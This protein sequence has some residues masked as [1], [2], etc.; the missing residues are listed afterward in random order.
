MIHATLLICGDQAR[1]NL[2]ARAEKSLS[3]G[4]VI[5]Q[6][7]DLVGR[8]RACRTTPT[9]S[10]AE[11]VATEPA[12]VL[13]GGLTVLMSYYRVPADELGAREEHY[14]SERLSHAYDVKLR[15]ACRGR[16]TPAAVPA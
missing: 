5:V 13:R 7:K 1:A 4:E 8:R 16:A 3:A 2:L 11:L 9:S 10:K 14:E 15:I 6:V 12:L